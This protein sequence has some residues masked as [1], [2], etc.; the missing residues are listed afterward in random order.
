MSENTFQT[1]DLY[2]AA[3]LRVAGVPYL[4]AVRGNGGRV[5]FVFEHPGVSVLRDLKQGYF[6]DRAK[7]S[8]LSFVQAVR[9]MKTIVH[10]VES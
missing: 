4:D 5:Q 8:A 2:Y 1:A 3:F 10:S 9:L 7:V 6:T